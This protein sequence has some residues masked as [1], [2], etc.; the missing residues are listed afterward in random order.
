M[1]KLTVI[2]PE[3]RDNSGRGLEVSQSVFQSG[4]NISRS[5]WVKLSPS[6]ALLKVVLAL[7]LAAFTVIMFF[8]MLIILGFILLAMAVMG[9][10]SG[11]TGKNKESGNS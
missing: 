2:R 10:F 1:G 11:I 8:F 9:L 7:P 3:H 6:N 5:L 4:E